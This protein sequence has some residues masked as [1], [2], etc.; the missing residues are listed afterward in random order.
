MP[1]PVATGFDAAGSALARSSRLTPL[2]LLAKPACSAALSFLQDAPAADLP[3]AV[4]AAAQVVAEFIRSPDSFQFDLASN[5]AVAQLASSPQHGALH[6]LLTIFLTGT[7]QVGLG[8]PWRCWL[9]ERLVGGRSR[10]V[11]GRERGFK[12]SAACCWPSRSAGVDCWWR[13]LQKQTCKE[14]AHSGPA[15]ADRGEPGLRVGGPTCKGLPCRGAPPSCLLAHPGSP[16]PSSRCAAAPARRTTRHLPAARRA[17]Q[18]WL[19]PAS[20]RTTR[21]P[22]CASSP[23]WA[24]RMARRRSLL[25]RSR[26][27]LASTTLTR[28]P[29]GS[30]LR[31]R[32]RACLPVLFWAGAGSCCAVVAL[33]PVA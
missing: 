25:T 13:R 14:T 33:Q 5:P 22:R 4:P 2:A 20:A 23:S 30:T 31:P 17:P 21:W 9:G 27:G 18:P 32:L 24:W 6:R 16:S 15:R 19:L 8:Q 7:I 26:W 3:G 1:L 10:E 28:P 11:A 12:C 29:A